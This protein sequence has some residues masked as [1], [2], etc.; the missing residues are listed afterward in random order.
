MKMKQED[1][2]DSKSEDMDED[3]KNFADSLKAQFQ[4]QARLVMMKKFLE[5][6]NSERNTTGLTGLSGFEPDMSCKYGCGKSFKN[7]G[8]IIS[9]PRQ[10]LPF[11]RCRRG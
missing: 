8:G 3:P 2:E 11:Q 9:T 1:D 5:N 7:H 4:E 6:V 10:L